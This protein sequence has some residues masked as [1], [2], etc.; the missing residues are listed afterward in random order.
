MG[1]AHRRGST[2][3]PLLLVIALLL[4]CACSTSYQDSGFTGGYSETRLDENVFKVSFNG[5]AYTKR[6]KV[7]DF[8]MLRSAE[9]ALEH[10]YTYFAVIDEN[11]YTGHST[12]T[13]PTTSRTT[14]SVDSYGNINA[15]TT[16][17]GGQTYNYSKPS[18]ENTIVCFKEKPEGVFVY[19]A[20]FVYDSI[21]EK[22]DIEPEE[23]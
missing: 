7:S 3:R 14:G 11:S 2:L 10:G 15:R 19:K 5:N 4:L 6:E 21:A 12:Y 8:T 16:T 13:T 1:Y 9:L 23:N 18:A 20:R 17:S 22:Y